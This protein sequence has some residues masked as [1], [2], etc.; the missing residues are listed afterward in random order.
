ML[1]DAFEKE[2]KRFDVE[3]VLPAW[4]GLVLQQ[5]EALAQMGVPTMVSTTD[6]SLREV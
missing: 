4:D 1:S 6:P 3:R 5:Q 2:L